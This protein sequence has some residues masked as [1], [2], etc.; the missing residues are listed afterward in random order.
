ME[1]EK[2]IAIR[3]ERAEA[4]YWI[5]RQANGDEILMSLGDIKQLN[6]LMELS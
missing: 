2:G 6:G 3:D 1:K 5:S 4:D